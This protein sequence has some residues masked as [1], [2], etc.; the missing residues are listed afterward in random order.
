[1]RFIAWVPAIGYM[2]LIFTLSSFSLRRT[3]LPKLSDKPIHFVEYAVLAALVT[4]AFRRT[5][6]SWSVRRVA[7]ASALLAAAYGATDELHQLYVPHRSASVYDWV[8]DALGAAA[9]AALLAYAW[10][11]EPKETRGAHDPALPR[12]DP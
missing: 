4:F 6:E 12:Q 11:K 2:A 8:A 7:V 3:P 5:R 10:R 9:M 1:L